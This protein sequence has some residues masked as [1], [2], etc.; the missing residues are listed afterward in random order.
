[1]YAEGPGGRIKTMEIGE[2]LKA[3]AG[4]GQG[5][6]T[7]RL[8]QLMTYCT[9][10]SASGVGI[11]REREGREIFLLFIEGE[12]QGAVLND[13]AGTLC[14]DTAVLHLRGTELFSFYPA[15]PDKVEEYA[16]GC[17]V[18]DRSH[19][20]GNPMGEI[21][22]LSR[23]EIAG[24]GILTVT[25]LRR[26]APQAG[27]HVSLRKAGQ[28]VG[29][30]ITAPTGKASFRLLFGRYDCVIMDRDHT[31]RHFPVSFDRAGTC[32]AFDLGN[33]SRDR[34]Q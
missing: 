33:P 5:T 17:R 1:M 23:R 21:P 28:L 18:Y 29:T 22:H 26:N 9:S 32:L 16:I 12:P 19:L 34:I 15:D 6:G 14:G 30:D 31:I 20:K 7:F 4:A 2:F 11:S 24:I 10:E 27:L 25:V 3:I 13:K 8:Q